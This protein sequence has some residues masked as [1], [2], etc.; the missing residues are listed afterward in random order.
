VVGSEAEKDKSPNG[1]RPRRWAASP[2]AAECRRLASAEITRA[3]DWSI[4]ENIDFDKFAAARRGK[5]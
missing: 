1:S 3:I 5:E 4:F 2:V